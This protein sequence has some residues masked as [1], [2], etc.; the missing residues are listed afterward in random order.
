MDIFSNF[1]NKFLSNRNTVPETRG[2]T[3]G[4]GGSGCPMGPGRPAGHGPLPSGALVGA[5]LKTFT[6]F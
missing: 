4:K 2:P 5:A 6:C 3:G 1:R